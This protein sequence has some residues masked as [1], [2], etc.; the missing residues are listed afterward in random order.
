MI[1]IKFFVTVD[2]I[3]LEITEKYA[4]VLIDPPIPQRQNKRM[5]RVKPHFVLTSKPEMQ[6]KLKLK[7]DKAAEET[8]KQNRLLLRDERK[9]QKILEKMNNIQKKADTAAARLKKK[10]EVV[11]AKMDK[12]SQMKNSKTA[13][14][15]KKPPAA[16]KAKQK[17][18]KNKKNC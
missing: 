1:I 7:E 9:Q 16:G 12:K 8:A 18:L 17:Q 14:K 2:G 15:L 3:D 10:A 5:L 11:A 13:G 4:G 6:R